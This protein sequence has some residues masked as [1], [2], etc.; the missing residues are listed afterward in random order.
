MSILFHNTHPFD[1]TIAKVYSSLGRYKLA[2]CS[3]PLFFLLCS[4]RGKYQGSDHITVSTNPRT[5]L[6]PICVIF[7]TVVSLWSILVAVSLSNLRLT[8]KSL[9]CI[10]SA[11]PVNYYKLPFN[12]EYK[13][14]WR[15]SK[16]GSLP[17]R[18]SC[19]WASASVKQPCR[20]WSNESYRFI[21]VFFLLFFCKNNAKQKAF[22][23]YF[24]IV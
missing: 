18:K 3:Y 24:V 22:S 6:S 1:S 15:H 16:F 10:T 8:F 20:I 2:L 11:F 4:K 7:K 13:N 12:I 21:M 5:L 19:N 14:R 17:F 23:F 9:F